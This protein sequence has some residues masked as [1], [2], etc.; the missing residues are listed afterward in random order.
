M[1]SIALSM[2][3]TRFEATSQT[4]RN[5]ATNGDAA[6]ALL[7][8]NIGN[9]GTVSGNS[10]Y[11][12]LDT[13]GLKKGLSKLRSYLDEGSYRSN[14]TS[15][16]NFQ[17]KIRSMSLEVFTEQ[18]GINSRYKESVS[19]SYTEIE[20]SIND[21]SETGEA[22]EYDS[23]FGKDGYWS[24]EKTSERLFDFVKSISGGN[25]ERLEQA[26]EGAIKGYKSVEKNIGSMPQVC[27]DTLDMLMQ[28]IDGYKES[29]VAQQPIDMT[30]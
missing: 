20:I 18:S 25:P 28:K 16:Q 10:A 19:F 30:A 8:K 7:S 4:K 14:G 27:V 13:E 11:M 29:L 23:V 3:S 2:T 17:I 21:S 9:G 15:L 12:S 26:R 1:Q 6:S 22:S 5:S 24:A